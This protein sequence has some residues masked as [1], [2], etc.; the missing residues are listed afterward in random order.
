[1]AGVVFATFAWTENRFRTSGRYYYHGHH[2]D[3][4]MI[5]GLL[6]LLVPMFLA[7]LYAAWVVRREAERSTWDS[8]L[9]T[10]IHVRDLIRAKWQACLLSAGRPI[11]VLSGALG[12]FLLLIGWKVQGNLRYHDFH[13]PRIVMLFGLL[14]GNVVAACA[15][16]ASV[17]LLMS[18]VCRTGL[19]AMVATFV[20]LATL[21]GMPL[22]FRRQ[23]IFDAHNRAAEFLLLATDFTAFIA[24]L[25]APLILILLVGVFSLRVRRWL[26]VVF[27]AVAIP[28]VSALLLQLPIILFLATLAALNVRFDLDNSIPPMSPIGFVIV[29]ADEVVYGRQTSSPFFVLAIALNALL[30]YVI[31]RVACW[32]AARHCGRIDEAPRRRRL[33]LPPLPKAA[34]KR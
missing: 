11:I 4:L 10:P 19:R 14:T 2:A 13:L 15:L 30:A 20:V 9:V 21:A 8:L 6:T 33:P 23:G 18:V 25:G 5:L 12:I 26:D 34:A 32:V 24:W 1:M 28:F 17:G 22:A 27:R 31:Y 7:A 16:A 29:A 3:E